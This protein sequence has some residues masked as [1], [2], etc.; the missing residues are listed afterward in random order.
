LSDAVVTNR[1]GREGR[2]AAGRANPA[3]QTVALSFQSPVAW[4]LHDEILFLKPSLLVYETTETKSLQGALNTIL[5]QMAFDFDLLEFQDN[6][7]PDS[8]LTA[9]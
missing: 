2:L 1:V 8:Y 9:I 7:T 6:G 4:D 5:A 3:C